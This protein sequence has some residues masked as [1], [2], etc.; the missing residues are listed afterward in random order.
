[1]LN[2]CIAVTIM[3]KYIYMYLLFRSLGNLLIP[4]MF[5]QRRKS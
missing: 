2:L 1:M 4:A 5:A 3:L